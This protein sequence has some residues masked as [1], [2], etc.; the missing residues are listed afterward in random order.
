MEE[1]SR[2]LRDVYSGRLRLNGEE[3][4][5][6][7]I[8][9]NNY[10]NALLSFKCLKEARSLLLKTIPV[11]RRV[12]GESHEVTLRARATYAEALYKDPA[13]TLGD[14]SEAVTT[15]EEIGPIARR[16][17]GGSHPLTALFEDALRR[18]RAALRARDAPSTSG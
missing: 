15:L 8:A 3:S 6:T 12:L 2:V 1:A 11:A 16:V 5:E 13:A 9:A 10:A 4:I 17:L 14:L 18:S 7:L